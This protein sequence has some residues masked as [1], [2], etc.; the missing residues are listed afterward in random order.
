MRVSDMDSSNTMEWIL[1][2][3][4]HTTHATTIGDHDLELSTRCFECLRHDVKLTTLSLDAAL[5]MLREH[6]SAEAW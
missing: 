4:M 3:A 6:T 5:S 1:C 2:L